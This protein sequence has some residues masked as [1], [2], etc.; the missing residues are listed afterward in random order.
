MD[1]YLLKMTRNDYQWRTNVKCIGDFEWKK[2]K[3]LRALNTFS[4]NILSIITS[5][6]L[7]VQ[8]GFVV[9]FQRNAT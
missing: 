1:V 2:I 8:I 4:K 9:F 7:L 5:E 6:A 3:T